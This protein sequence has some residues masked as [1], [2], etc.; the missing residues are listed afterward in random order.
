MLCHNVQRRFGQ[1]DDWIFCV[2]LHLF[3]VTPFPTFVEH[4]HHFKRSVDKLIPL[5][6]Q[7]NNIG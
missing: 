6:Y 5:H 7:S 4:E 1:S 3:D 2:S